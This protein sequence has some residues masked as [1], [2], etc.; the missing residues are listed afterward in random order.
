MQFGQT[1][2]KLAFM[3]DYRGECRVNELKGWDIRVQPDIRAMMGVLNQSGIRSSFLIDY[4][5][6]NLSSVQ[7]LYPTRP[8]VVFHCVVFFRRRSSV[9]NRNGFKNNLA[10]NRLP[11]F[12]EGPV[13]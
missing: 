2:S 13:P 7:F 4:E 3:S 10:S 1:G 9:P 6:T 12:L 11:D 8:T 5:C